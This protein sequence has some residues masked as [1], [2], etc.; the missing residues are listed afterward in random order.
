MFSY[1]IPEFMKGRV[2]TSEHAISQ[3][4]RNSKGIDVSVKGE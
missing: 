3:M 4:L 1:N 2:K